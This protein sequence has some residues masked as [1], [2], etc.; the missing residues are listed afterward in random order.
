MCHDF[1]NLLGCSDDKFIPSLGETSQKGSH[2]GSL[3]HMSQAALFFF[4]SWRWR[5]GV[6][7]LETHPPAGL[8]QVL[9]SHHRWKEPVS[10]NH[11]VF[12]TCVWT[13]HCAGGSV[14]K[15]L[16]AWSQWGWTTDAYMA[17]LSLGHLGHPPLTPLHFKHIG[18]WH[19]VV[20]IVLKSF[21]CSVKDRSENTFGLK[22]KLF[23]FLFNL[24]NFLPLQYSGWKGAKSGQEQISS[25]FTWGLYF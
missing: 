16:E 23:H 17:S 22:F 10:G 19:K 25:S 15:V 12:S 11:R 18:E 8:C 14:H 20:T 6:G 21:D 4:L 3:V 13:G 9:S 2:M 24:V 5:F 1:Q 7:L